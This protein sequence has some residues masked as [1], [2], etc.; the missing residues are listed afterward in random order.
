MKKS[1][2]RP[3]K[4][5]SFS[6]RS[7]AYCL[8]FF[9]CL[10]FI[11]SCASYRLEK[12]LDL[13]S[14]EFLSKVRYIITKQERKIFLNLPPSDRDNFIEEFWRKRDPDPYTE[15]NEFKEEYFAR[16]EEANRL[17][18]EGGTPGWLQDRGRIYILIG[19]PDR[20]D[21]Y[22]RGSSF[23]GKP[24]EVWHYGFF[25]IVF[26]DHAWN[27]DYKLEPLSAQQISEINKA[28]KMGK[29]EIAAKEK[30][31]IFNFDLDIEK[32]GPRKVIIRIAIPYKNIW[33]VNEENQLKTTLGLST[34]IFDSSENKVWAHKKD[35]PLS[36]LEENLKDIFGKDYIIE[37]AVELEPGK[38]SLTVELENKTD[39]RRVRKKTKFSV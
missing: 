32:V 19:P 10:L 22:P 4:F 26:I 38:Y 12:L 25:P 8:L 37:V 24:M 28:Q 3:K 36:L 16:I 6:I 39:K 23:Y 27:G 30:E 21:Q 14:K 18:R 1:V 7:P 29:S 2:Y 33:F 9:L 35:Y 34:E 15:E 20:R 13:E 5:F 11:E 17:F 31:S